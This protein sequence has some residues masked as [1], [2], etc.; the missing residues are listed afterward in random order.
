MSDLA[1]D[2]PATITDSAGMKTLCKTLFAIAVIIFTAQAHAVMY[3]ARPYD[4]NM[5]RW[6]SR[7]PIGEEGG[8]NLYAM[9]SNNL[10]NAID[11][12]GE[13]EIEI[14]INRDTFPLQRRTRIP[15]ATIGSFKMS[16]TVD[17]KCEKKTFD[18]ISGVTME[19]PSLPFNMHLQ[20][21][22][23]KQYPM[24][25]GTYEADYSDSGPTGENFKLKTPG[26]G[27][28]GVY[29]HAGYTPLSSEGCILVGS[30]WKMGKMAPGGTR[31]DTEA[32]MP[33]IKEF[34][35]LVGS[36]EK[37]G[38]MIELYKKVKKFDKECCSKTKIKV[39]ISG[40]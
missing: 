36:D 31:P 18:S 20:Y 34:P 6:L 32:P 11:P 19:P 29:I 24:P 3:L 30:S 1:V 4:P 33:G 16:V 39:T 9:V 27:W 35:F 14:S 37:M 10:V 38:K 21:G 40:G 17:P 26:T 13:S 7:D 2:S 8:V 25:A 5:G 23:S 28:S 15:L 22:K 12:L